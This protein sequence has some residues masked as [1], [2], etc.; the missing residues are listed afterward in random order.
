MKIRS[1]SEGSIASNASPCDISC[2]AILWQRYADLSLIV[3]II[4]GFAEDAFSSSIVKVEAVV[5]LQPAKT[6]ALQN[7]SLQALKAIPQSTCSLTVRIHVFAD[8][9]G[10]NLIVYQANLTVACD[11][12]GSLAVWIVTMP[13]Y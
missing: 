2:N 9:R 6:V 7:V 1:Q 13:A 11:G 8:T 10:I 4:K 3:K 5:I 12:V